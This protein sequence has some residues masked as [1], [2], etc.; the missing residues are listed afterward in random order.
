MSSS[1]STD[2][3]FMRQAL[4]LAEQGVGLCSPNPCVGAVLVSR[5]GK[6][7]GSGS[8]TY[9]SV[10]HAEV[11]ALEHAAASGESVRGATLYINLEPC[12]HQGRTGPCADALI[13]AGIGRVVAAMPDPNP[14][15]S[16]KGFERLRAA[17]I[18]VSAGLQQAEAEKLNEAFAHY[19]QTRA[20]LVTLKAGMTLDGK[21]A[22]PPAGHSAPSATGGWITSEAARAPVQELRHAS[23]ATM[24]GVGTIIDDD[25]LLTDRSGRKRRRPL[26]RVVLDS[27]LRMPLTS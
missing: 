10:T 19:I 9:E 23:D 27:R 16:G 25:P 3:R 26:Q 5:E 17:G 24:V 6:V 18:E 7:I 22:P 20:P 15:V 8:H 14:L 12:S 4:A 11:L 2:E 21:I 1:A 13:A